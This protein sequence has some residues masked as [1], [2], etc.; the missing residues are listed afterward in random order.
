M[1]QNYLSFK[2]YFQRKIF[3]FNFGIKLKWIKPFKSIVWMIL[4][5]EKVV[6]NFWII[7]VLNQHT[8]IH[9]VFHYTTAY[10]YIYIF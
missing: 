7:V 3:L 6:K 5:Y 1:I 4:E 10:K 2:N 8:H 9:G